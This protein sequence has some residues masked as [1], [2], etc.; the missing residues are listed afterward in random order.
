MRDNNKMTLNL[1]Y[2]TT[3]KRG[4][5]P[6]MEVVVDL[7]RLSTN[8][9]IDLT[10]AE[11]KVMISSKEVTD[12]ILL[13]GRLLMQSFPMFRQLGNA[14]RDGIPTRFRC[15]VSKLGGLLGGASIEERN[16]SGWLME[17]RIVHLKDLSASSQ[18]VVE[19]G[20]E[21]SIPLSKLPQSLFGSDSRV[22]GVSFFPPY[23]L[24]DSRR[25]RKLLRG[26]GREQKEE[27]ELFL[28]DDRTNEESE[29]MGS[30]GFEIAQLRKVRINA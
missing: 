3:D 14:G 16:Y 15:Q 1:N 27:D 18:T 30:F 12:S 22:S 19:L 24:Q 7:R 23:S 29:H 6:V 5:I 10:C 13:T 8:Y 25:D 4:W 17:I 21:V 26:L 20:N 9:E 28:L 2:E 11:S